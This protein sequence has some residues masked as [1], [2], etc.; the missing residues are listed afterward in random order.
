MSNYGCANNAAL[1]AMI[2]DPLDLVQ[3]R[4]AGGATD[5]ITSSKA[6]RAYRDTAPSGS[7]GLKAESTSKAGN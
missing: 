6:V 7:S 3:G 1:A 2:A 4:G 5:P